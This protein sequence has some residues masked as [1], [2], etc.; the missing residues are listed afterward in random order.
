MIMSD[1]MYMQAIYIDD[2]GD[3]RQ[4]GFGAVMETDTQTVDAFKSAKLH[5]VPI[6]D[7]RFLIDLHDRNGDL[8]ET[9]PV[10][11]RGYTKV[12]GEPVLTDEEYV[13]IDANHWESVRKMA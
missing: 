13:Q 1:A 9:I 4:T 3:A 12:T 11:E 5:E 7:A 8:L 10:G 2:N 6:N